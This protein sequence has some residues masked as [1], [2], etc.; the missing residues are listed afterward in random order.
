MGKILIVDD[1]SAELANLK[2]IVVD[3]GHFPVMI[4]DGAQA[5]ERAKVEKPDL[6]FM[7]IVMPG[8]DGYEACRQLLGDPATKGIP[9][10]MVSSKKQ[11]ADQLWAKMQGAHSLIGKPYTKEDILATIKSVVG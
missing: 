6:I 11:K 10:V 4:N 3:A 8:V 1:S 7:D 2:A 9:V 5:L